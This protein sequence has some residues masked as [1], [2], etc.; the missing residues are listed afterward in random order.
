MRAWF[1]P[2]NSF[3]KI[4][5]EEVGAGIDCGR[6]IELPIYYTTPT[7]SSSLVESVHYTVIACGK[8]VK[9]GEF[10]PKSTVQ[11]A[12]ASSPV[13]VSKAVFS[14]TVDHTFAPKFKL[15]VYFVRPD[16]EVVDDEV[17][18][19]TPKCLVNDVSV[20]LDAARRLPG[21]SVT[22][23]LGAAPGSLCG[24]SVADKSVALMGSGNTLKIDNVFDFLTRREIGYKH[25]GGE[26]T[27]YCEKLN[28]ATEAASSGR[29]TTPMR[30]RPY[31]GWQTTR[32][33]SITAFR[34]A[35][36]LAITDM[37]LETRPC[38]KEEHYYSFGGFGRFADWIGD[39]DDD[40]EMAPMA[41]MARYELASFLE[42]YKSIQI[43][44]T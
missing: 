17:S 4:V 40:A 32:H 14:L 25:F 12:A 38:E 42:V 10:K 13:S 35:G 28:A 22:M 18:M 6:N 44:V 3:L 24:F 1:S 23:T 7:G 26:N 39:Y 11:P 9:E 41:G 31:W 37:T 29:R 16:G 27:K 21:E 34:D 19:E 8:L 30:W 20:Q 5:D 2:S 15:L 33:D 36:I 43:V